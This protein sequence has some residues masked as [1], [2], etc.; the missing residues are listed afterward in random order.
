M[1]WQDKSL[2]T[3]WLGMLNWWWWHG[4][5]A[6]YS[7][8]RSYAYPRGRRDVLCCTALL[9]T[10]DHRPY[11]SLSTHLFFTTDGRSCPKQR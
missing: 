5:P 8:L 9:N 2:F 3:R 11:S 1:G 10:G 6:R 7:M 4:F